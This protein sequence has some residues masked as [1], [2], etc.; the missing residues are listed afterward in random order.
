M[1]DCAYRPHTG[2]AGG[3]HCGLL[4]RRSIAEPSDPI[5][6]LTHAPEAA[7]LDQLVR[8]AGTRWSIESLFEQGK[9]EV[10]LDQYEVCSWTG[11]H[12]HITTAMLA[13]A[14]LAAVQK[15]AV[16]GCGP[17]KPGRGLAAISRPSRRAGDARGSAPGGANNAPEH[18]GGRA[19]G[20]KHCRG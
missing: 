20:S 4:V 16:G 19:S 10:G 7:T 12:R 5:F 6:Y 14:D 2:G 9:G 11:W 17:E 3:L 1:Y 15:D 18:R 13:L 8:I